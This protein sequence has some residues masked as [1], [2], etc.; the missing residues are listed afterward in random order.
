MLFLIFTSSS[1]HR[2]FVPFIRTRSNWVVRLA[3]IIGISVEKSN[4]ES[5]TSRWIG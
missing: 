4:N 2:D 3:M 5:N 1:L